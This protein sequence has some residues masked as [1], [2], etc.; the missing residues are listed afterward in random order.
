MRMQSS[1]VPEAGGLGL[2]TFAAT[3]ILVL[4]LY[5]R[6]MAPTVYGLDSAELTAG[7]YLLGIVHAPGSPTYLL[8]GHLFTWLPFGDV[9]YRVNL[10]SACSGAVA[11]GFMY[12]ILWRLT[13]SRLESFAGALYI[14]TTYYFWV[15]ALAA[16]LYALHAAFIA[17]LVWLGMVWQETRRTS[18]LALLCLLYGVGLGNH[19]SLS[20]LAP[21]FVVLVTAGMPEIWRRPRLLMTGA[22]A[23]VAGWCVYLYL[24]V[25]AAAGVPMNYARDFGVDVATWQGFWWMVT[26][27]MFGREMLGV[28]IGALPGELL[29]Y[30]YRLWSNF[31]G[32]GFILG[33]IGLQVDF[34]RRRQI[35]LPLLLMFLGH[36][37]F[38]VTYAVADKEFMLLP[39]FLFFGVWVV[40]GAGEIARYMG[41][42]GGVT[43]S[44][45][46]LLLVM[47]ASNVVVNFARVDISQDWSARNRGEMLLSWLPPETLY[48]ATWA[49]A[50]LID[51]LQYVEADRTDVDMLNVFLVRGTRRRE[52]VED[53]LRRGGPIYASA[54]VNLGREFVFELEEA[55]DC[56]QV[57]RSTDPICLAAPPSTR[58]SR[59]PRWGAHAPNGG[60]P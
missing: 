24:P 33:F 40:L 6:T 4:L 46:V 55:C 51:Y 52:R 8:L 12:A 44:A 28:S 22:L 32:L 50:A 31:L 17:G 30:F 19:L 18:H 54:P 56:Y 37:M 10:F 38:A 29:Q 47:T 11:V 41:E 21:G 9:G 53:Q 27:S 57:K 14:G 5:L 16:E 43:V 1:T 25:R 23:L 58:Q 60:N 7:A 59:P 20:V 42:R 13:R 45:A 2:A 15:T 49:D 39:T 3:V 35:H 34:N 26:G 36:L 48:L